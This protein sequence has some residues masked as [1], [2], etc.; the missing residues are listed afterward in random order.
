MSTLSTL[1]VRDLIFSGTHGATGREPFA[2]QRFAVNIKIN[3][4]IT[5]AVVSDQLFDTYDYKNAAD[6]ARDVIEQRHYVLIESIA[7]EIANRITASPKVVFVSVELRKLDFASNGISGIVVTRKRIPSEQSSYLRDFDINHVYSELVSKG[8]VS[9]PILT[10]AYREELLREAETYEYKKQP[11]IVGPANVKEDL[12]STTQF[13]EGSL[14]FGLRDQFQHIFSEKLTNGLLS[15][16]SIPLNFNEMSLQLYEKGSIGVTPHMDN[17]SAINFVCVFI[18]TGKADFALCKDR[19]G[20]E[21]QFLDTSPGNVILLRGPGFAG[22]EERPF[23]F[24]T[25][26][27]ERRIVFGLRQDVK[28]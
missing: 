9:V 3:L 26:V 27:S 19:N 13:R 4:D 14:F 18:L 25:N 15:P 12:S 11:Y 6:I 7:S 22:I 1:F 5:S 20:S 8:G 28:K 21:P 17:K 2:S 23:H 10:P 24:V 16:F